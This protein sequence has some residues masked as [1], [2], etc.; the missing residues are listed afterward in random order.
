MPLYRRSIV[1]YDVIMTAWL[2]GLLAA[3][4]IT[5]GKESLSECGYCYYPGVR[6]IQTTARRP[7]PARQGLQ[8]GPAV[9]F[10]KIYKWDEKQTD[11]ENY[12][13]FKQMSPFISMI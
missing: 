8:S 4:S 12:P 10:P 9:F 2:V 11:S 3:L 5:S 1:S 13:I 6:G 7:D